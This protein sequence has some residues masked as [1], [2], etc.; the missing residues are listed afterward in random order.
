[1]EACGGM[2]IYKICMC[3]IFIPTL[4]W[5]GCFLTDQK[6]GSGIRW[7]VTVFDTCS[8]VCVRKVGWLSLCLPFGYLAGSVRFGSPSP[9]R[10]RAAHQQGGPLEVCGGVVSRLE[11]L[12]DVV[13]MSPSNLQV[14]HLETW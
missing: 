1:M 7:I 11:W 3:A 2:P 10:K 13:W 6:L 14:C 5:S 9:A 8:S 12:S 4:P